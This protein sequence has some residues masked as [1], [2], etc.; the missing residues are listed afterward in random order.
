MAGP[1]RILIVDDNVDTAEYV[2]E[3]LQGVGYE[4]TWAF[5]GQEALSQLRSTPAEAAG[6]AQ[7]FDLLILDVMMPGIDGYEVCRRIKSDPSLRHISVIMV[8]GLGSTPNK[9]KGPCG[10]SL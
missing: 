6:V 3:L 2:A 7:A 8:T 1:V 4:T 10:F 5:D 9:T